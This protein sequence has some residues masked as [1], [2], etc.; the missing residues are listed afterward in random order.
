MVYV[1]FSFLFYSKTYAVEDPLSRPNNFMGIHILFPSELDQAKDLVNSNGGEWGYVTIPIQ[2][3]DRDLNK[4]QAFM[5]EAKNLHVIPI[6]RLATQPNPHNTAVW[7]KPNPSDIL[8]FANFL[9]SLSWPT[10]NKYV[11]L[12]NE[13]NRF[14]EWG[15]EYPDPSGYADLVSYASQVFK[16]TDPD[17]YLILAGMDAS[18]PNDYT[19]YINGFTYLTELVST[20]HVTDEVDGFASHSYP[21]PAFAAAPFE[22]SKTGVATYRFE[23]TLINFHAARKLPVFITETGWSDKTVPDSVISRYYEMTFQNIWGKDKDKIVAITPFLLNSAGGPFEQ[24]SFY[25][26]GQPTDYLKTVLSLGK[27]KGEPDQTNIQL[28]PK[29]DAH[30]LPT[31]SFKNEKIASTNGYTLSPYVKLYFKT[32]LGL[33]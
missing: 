11:V 22:N 18:A 13:V 30:E 24:F 12:F 31:S 2:I 16:K 5:D 10:K 6:I 9:S 1:L 17:F 27:T 26:N 14:D 23:Y 19:H 8:D 7:R 28:I 29:A 3:G 4:W 32:I 21:N 15:G 20:T 25:K 33:N